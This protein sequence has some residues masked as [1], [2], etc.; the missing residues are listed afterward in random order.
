MVEQEE[1]MR[2][3]HEVSFLHKV[4]EQKPENLPERWRNEVRDQIRKQKQ[5]IKGLQKEITELEEL[6]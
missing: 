4:P 3:T 5:V 1:M 6:I 2:V